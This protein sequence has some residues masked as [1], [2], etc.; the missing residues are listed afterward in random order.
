GGCEDLFVHRSEGERLYRKH[1]AECH[2]VN[3]NGD[4][5]GY[6]GNAYADLLDDHWKFGGDSGSMQGVVQAGVFGQMPKFDQLT[7]QE[8]RAVIDHVRVLRGEISAED[9]D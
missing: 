6:M 9:P 2:G 4:T 1:C 7:A 5:P 8:V 3:G